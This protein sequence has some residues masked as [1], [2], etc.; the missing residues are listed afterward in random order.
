[1]TFLEIQQAVQ[2][3]VRD[4]RGNVLTIIKD[5]VNWT[6]DNLASRHNWYF[7]R[8]EGYF[9]TTAT[10]TTGTI[11]VTEDSVT[12]TGTSTVW[13]YRMVGS[14]LEVG[15]TSVAGSATNKYKIRKVVSATSLILEHPYR[16]ATATAQ[17]YIVYKDE[18]HLRWDV[19][20]INMIRFL[21]G[22]TRVIRFW[23]DEL[24]L[25]EA[26]PRRTG[27][28]ELYRPLGLSARGYYATG[29]VSVSTTA[30][31]GLAGTGASADASFIGRFFR[32]ASESRIY[33]IVSVPAKTKF[34]LHE[35]YGGTKTTGGQSYDIDPPGT[36]IVQLY[37]IP[38]T[39][40]YIVYE[41][42]KYPERL[43]ADGDQ[44]EVPDKWHQVLVL[45]AVWEC[46]QQRED[47]N[48][49]VLQ[50]AK[51]EYEQF[52]EK[53][54]KSQDTQENDR[55]RQFQHIGAR[56]VRRAG[57]RLPSNYPADGNNW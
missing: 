33:E 35:K 23:Q 27:D 4:V 17:S 14:W 9:A 41:Y 29:T 8:R 21:A 55:V 1:M 57:P 53:E 20:R 5:A 39:K 12:V 10:Y 51:G 18:Y 50:A 38:T 3:R 56:Y 24:Y 32:V 47:V 13:T 31:V 40:V 45:G 25:Y 22:P 52:I 19:D 43:Y 7:W 54:M 34:I 42:Q 2:R 49:T 6:Q 48:P 36:P 11:A 26:N 30:T 37:P 16:S 46:L 15:A 44:P 28:P